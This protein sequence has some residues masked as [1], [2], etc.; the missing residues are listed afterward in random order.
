MSEQ[1][2]TAAEILALPEGGGFG[3]RI[4]ERD[5]KRVAIPIQ[6]P[7]MCVFSEPDD[8]LFCAD[9][10]GD[11]WKLGRYADGRWFRKRWHRL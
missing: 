9:E 1:P 11:Y 4:E 5:G 8:V 10:N 2:R 6:D 3:Q 7:E